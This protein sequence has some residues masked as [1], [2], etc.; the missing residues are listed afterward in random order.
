MSAYQNA[1]V[2]AFV[3]WFLCVLPTI[4]MSLPQTLVQGFAVTAARQH[5]RHRSPG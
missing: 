4:P 5:I 1:C 2:I 3:V